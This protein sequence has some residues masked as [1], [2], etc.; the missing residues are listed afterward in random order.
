[1]IP[2]SICRHI[3]HINGID[4]EMVLQEENILAC[5]PLRYSDSEYDS[6]SNQ[7]VSCTVTLVK[8]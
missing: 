4:V 5:L 1:M 8:L 6:K 7:L 2:H 3:V